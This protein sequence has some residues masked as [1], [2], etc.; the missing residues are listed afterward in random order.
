[1]NDNNIKQSKM[2]E[3]IEFQKSIDECLKNI[4]NTNAFMLMTINRCIDYTKASRGVKL[5]P[6]YETVDLNETLK[7]PLDC[8]KNIQERII[9][10]LLPMSGEIC[11]HLI[12]DKQWLQ[13]NVLCLLSNAVKY[14]T[15]GEVTIKVYVTDSQR[16]KPHHTQSPAAHS[17][18]HSIERIEKNSYSYH[19]NG[20]NGGNGGDTNNNSN[21][22]SY[23]I[24]CN[25]NESSLRSQ[26]T[27][28]KKSL[29]SAVTGKS[30]GGGARRI[31]PFINTIESN[32]HGEENHSSSNRVI[33]EGDIENEKPLFEKKKKLSSLDEETLANHQQRQ[34]LSVYASKY[35][36]FDVEDTGI[37][38]STEAMTSLFNP[39]RQAQ[40]LAGGTGLG[41]YSLSKRIEALN[42]SFGVSNRKDGKQGS[43][44]WFSIPYRPDVATAESLRLMRSA[45]C[46]SGLGKDELP[47]LLSL[48]NPNPISSLAGGDGEKRE[49]KERERSD[50]TTDR[51][52]QR[53][54]EGIKP[55][56][57][58]ITPMAGSP[59]PSIIIPQKLPPLNILVVDDAPSILKMC[60]MM[61]K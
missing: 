2:I 6:K 25:S 56:G 21:N 28:I 23:R 36:R 24:V 5:M 50:K 17:S 13:E 15:G 35:L 32:D 18:V 45:S 19:G 22:N 30:G 52:K 51:E 29:F 4:R 54:E 34:S 44:F 26:G 38:M 40:R 14:S 37:G 39:F 11:S 1:V 20:S 8:M 48:I 46:E 42:G 60:T 10:Q 7:L 31:V 53:K 47:R 61:L 49:D 57:E 9:I 16:S 33:E 59:I 12:T 27:T 41:L 55:E 43:L 3:L 58:T